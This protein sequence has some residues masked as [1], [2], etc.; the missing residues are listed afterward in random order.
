MKYRAYPTAFWLVLFLLI[1]TSGL[2]AQNFNWPEDKSTAQTNFVLYTDAKKQK[3]YEAAVEPMTWLHENAP[4]LNPRIYID[5]ADIYEELADKESDAAKKTEYIDKALEMYDLRLQYFSDENEADIANRKANTAFKL[6]YKKPSE[7]NRLM[8]LF[9]EA[10]D[11]SNDDLVYYNIVPFMSVLKTLYEKGEIDDEQLLGMYDRLGQMVE[12][13]VAAG[14]KYASKYQEA[15]ENM[16]SIFASFF[17]MSCDQILE[18]LMPKLEEN[19]DDVDLAKRVISLSLASSCTDQD[20]FMTAAETLFQNGEE[21]PGLAKALGTRAM[22][23]EDYEKAKEWFDKVLEISS[24]D[25]QKADVIMD[26]GIIALKEGQRTSARK[27]FLQAAN[28]DSGLAE[29]AY[30][31]IGNMYMQSYEQCKGGEDVVQDRAVFIAAYE[32]YRKAG[33]TAQ[34]ANAKEQFPSK[35]EVFTYNKEV[36]DQITVGCWVNETVTIRTRD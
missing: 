18:K 8:G 21:D 11:K 13:Q 15:G 5:G 25:E 3:N 20:F 28:T 1:A 35:E 32:K 14:G 7:Y 34:M 27:Y 19:P 33:N 12:K 30:N 4:D 2:K 23:A 31:S 16:D 10:M 26:L 9:T 6:L 22:V 24:S 29:K 36:G 17:T